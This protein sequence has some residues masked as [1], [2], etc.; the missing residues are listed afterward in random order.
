MA[1]HPS[2]TRLICPLTSS[3]VA[4][5]RADMLQAAHEGADAVECRLDYL[6]TPPDDEE[7]ALLLSGAPVEVIV[8][9]RP[10]RE[11]GHFQGPEYRRLDIL[12]HAAALGATFIDVE[13][14]T[15]A[16][17]RP[18]GAVILSR[19]D[20][21]GRP[22]DLE[23]L[24]RA[25][26]ASG[27]AVNK[28]AFMSAGPADALAAL[29]L[30]RSCAKPTLALAMGEAGMASRILA[31]KFGAFGTFASLRAGAESAPGQPSMSR[32][33]Q[34]Y[35]WDRIDGETVVCGVIGCPVA[36][37]M[38]PAIHNAAFEAVGF[39]GV[40]VPLRIEPGRENFERFM[41]A[42]L[43]RPWTDWR[44]LSVTLPHKENALAY[45][46]A[47]NCDELAGRIGAINTITIDPGGRLRGMNTDYAAAIDAVCSQ[48][49]ISREELSGKSVAV[50]GAGGVSRAIVAALVE[51]GADV[52]IYNRTVTRAAKLAEEFSCRAGPLADA[53]DAEAEIVI[54]C[55]SVG[56][57][58]DTDACPLERVPPSVKVVFDTIYNPVE[59][60]LLRRA[61]EAGCRR[62]TGV[63]MFVNQA[64]GQFEAWTNLTAPRDV[65]RKV[66]LEHLGEK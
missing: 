7:L 9:C 11:G 36:H 19:H 3:T 22:G 33:K 20:F 40:Y 63:E 26:D 8:T 25:L 21:T 12:R 62:I 14:D 54:N 13:A 46:G 18:D 55:T 1:V 15:P 2:Q 41:D 58:P 34:L 6:V 10:R 53:A 45:V 27:D 65:M 59:T 39:N 52:S 29:D 30:I 48:M 38:S 64:V 44:G 51:Y 47:G 23:E 57:H 49:R 37:S 24:A 50:L 32:L 61:A 60:L 16:E 66:V 17:A 43:A 28:L 31:R 56:M 35:R 4:Q 5:M 42:L